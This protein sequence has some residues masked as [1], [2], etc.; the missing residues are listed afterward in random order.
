VLRHRADRAAVAV[1]VGA[2]LAHAA[3]Y[4]LATPLVAACVT[5]PLFLLSITV[6]PL[7]HHHQHLNVFR[8]R[9]LNRIYEVV[10]A[11]QTG[12]GP[13]TWVL[14]HNLGH[15]LN[16]L[17]QPPSEPADESHWTRS[18]G[19]TMA[20]LE[21][22]LHLF[23]DHQRDVHRMGRKH[24]RIYRQFW[25]WRIPLYAI[26]AAL[27]VA[28]PWNFAWT[29][30]LPAALTLLHTCWATYEHHAGQA[31]TTHYEATVNRV[32]SLYNVLSWN[33]GYHTAHHLRPAVH[34]SELPAL[35]EE[36]RERIPDKQVL[37]TFW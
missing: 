26:V 16:Y 3:A 22:A 7:N 21:Y 13:Y 31:T 35:H 1:V 5:V 19:T 30:A 34:W 36:I 12:A 32:H 14:H 37:T 24:P 17:N 11:L 9:G 10:L 18:D 6:A 23:A 4:W 2:F 28:K 8:S 15:H 29:F 33:L 25:L 20:R 27:A